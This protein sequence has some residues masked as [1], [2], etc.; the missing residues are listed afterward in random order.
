ML[1][2]AILCLQPTR[3]QP[4]LDII[5]PGPPSG[6]VLREQPGL[7]ITNCRTHTQKVYVRLDPCNVYRAHYPSA[8]AQYSWAGA[9][10]T[11]D[12]LTHAEADVKH[13]L[14]QLEKMTV[15]Q[16]ELGGHNRHSKRFLGALLGAAADIG[17][18]TETA[19]KRYKG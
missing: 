12:S 11:E 5:S 10:W 18:Q 2:F 16:G 6:I 1:W 7:L 4:Q 19:K 15:T 13:M 14:S 3:G 8:V 17:L 9:R